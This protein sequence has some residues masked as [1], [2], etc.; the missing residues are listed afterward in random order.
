[1]RYLIS[2]NAS[3]NFFKID[4]TWFWLVAAY[5]YSAI[6]SRMHCFEW[7]L[8]IRYLGTVHTYILISIL[9]HNFNSNYFSWK[10]MLY[11]VLLLLHTIVLLHL[12]N[13]G[14]FDLLVSVATFHSVKKFGVTFEECC[15]LMSQ[16]FE[17]SCDIFASLLMVVVEFGPIYPQLAITWQ[18]S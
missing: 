17:T 12:A 8:F 4:F 1:M 13:F 11:F 2:I 10:K 5:N 9:N 6:L 16:L 7:H 3:P 18:Q 15:S 14:L